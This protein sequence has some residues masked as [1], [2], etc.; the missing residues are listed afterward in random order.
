[1]DL[2]E[3]E[4]QLAALAE[5][6]AD[7]L[8]APQPAQGRLVLVAGE[9]GVGKSSLLEAFEDALPGARW[10]WGGCDGGFT[11]RRS[12]RSS[13]WPTQLG[14]TVADAVR[15]ARPRTELFAALLQALG[16]PTQ[17]TVVVLED[18]HWA[19]EATLDL[20]RYLGRRLR[21][22]RGLV[23]ATYRDEQLDPAHPLRLVLW[24]ARR[25]S[26]STRRLDLPRSPARPLRAWRRAA[27]STPRPSTP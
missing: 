18:V 19:D 6:A 10:A 26:A 3:R 2:L 8:S 13:T 1:M 14:G 17:A 9:A 22:Q 16:D 27:A 4:P 21:R 7:A 25:P 23:L 20:V 24:R 5:Y 15:A 11:P 12:V